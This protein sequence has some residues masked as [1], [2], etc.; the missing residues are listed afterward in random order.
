RQRAQGLVER[1]THPPSAD[2][3]DQVIESRV[4]ACLGRAVSHPG[5]LDLTVLD[6]RVILR[7]P[8]FTYEADH[9]VRA[10]RRVPGV[11]EVVDRMERHETAGSISSL[12]GKGRLRQRRVW[13]PTA[14][15]AATGF[16]A[17]L[18]LYGWF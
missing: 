12:Q 8:V 18:F 9:V 14:Q 5:A 7:G 11:R 6:G 17:A 3:P 16:G 4:R 13:S 15:V 1:V 2:A 10:V